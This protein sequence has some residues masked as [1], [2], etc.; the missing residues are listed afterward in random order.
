MYYQRVSAKIYIQ[1]HRFSTVFSK[2][3]MSEFWNLFSVAET[4]R[5]LG[6]GK[7]EAFILKNES[8]R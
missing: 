5:G 1:S 4:T 3:C 2:I 7:S 8:A 6:E